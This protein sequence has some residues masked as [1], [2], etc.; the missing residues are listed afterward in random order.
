MQHSVLAFIPSSARHGHLAAFGSP[1]VHRAADPVMT[2]E[3]ES[4]NVQGLYFAGCLSHGKDFKR[5]AGG[6]IH[7]FRYSVILRR[8]A[9]PLLC[10]TLPPYIDVSC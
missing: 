9:D 2:H 6:F 8:P 1:H 7:G 3:Y 10:P 4:K 5:G